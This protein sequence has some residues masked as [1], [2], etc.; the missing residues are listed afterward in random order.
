MK[1]ER[2]TRVPEEGKRYIGLDVHKHYIT[3]GGLN[4][5]QEIVLRPRDVEMERFK[6]WAGS[7]FRKSDEVVLE[8]STNTWDVYDTVAPL[9]KRVVVAHAAEVKQIA[10]SRVKTDNQDVIR[11]VRLLIADI[12]PE[13]W[14]PPVEVRELRAMIS[15]RWRLVKMSTAIQN[16][17]HSLLHRHNI[18]APQGKIDTGENR[19]WW[20]QVKLSELENLRLKQEIKTLRLIRENIVEVEKELGRLSNSERWGNEAVYLMQLPGVGIIVT[21]TILSAIGDIQRFE[22]PKK[23]VGYAGLGAGVHDSGQKHQDKGI[24]KFGRK[25]L[26]WALVEASWQAVR[27]NPSWR[28]EYD[29]L[30]KRKHQNQAIVAI[31]HKLLVTIWYL[32]I[33]QEPY[34]KSN[35]EDLAYKMLTWAWHMDKSALSGM[36][37]QQFAKYGLLR[38]GKGAELTRIVRSGKP[39]RIATKEEVLALK[40]ELHLKQ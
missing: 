26:R 35:E 28:A 37:N 19:E 29:R 33:R 23:L 7:N 4:A 27:S 17:M 38:L 12:V 32:L 3:V 6:T 20:E 9:V 24:T 2:N 14:V 22:S 5:Q 34:K 36:T 39:R 11:L 13:V 31:A 21:M 30:C 25:E 15:Y 40:P 8:A 1:R 18:Q 10:N 16:R